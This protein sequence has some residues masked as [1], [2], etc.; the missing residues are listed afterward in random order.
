MSCKPEITAGPCRRDCRIGSR[1]CKL[2]RHA[3]D[4][5]EVGT[6]G[7]V[8]RTRKRSGVGPDGK[9]EAETR[10]VLASGCAAEAMER[11]RTVGEV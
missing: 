4:I 1:G 6:D 2:Q 9:E 5:L 8:R 11:L 10:T 3:E 7:E